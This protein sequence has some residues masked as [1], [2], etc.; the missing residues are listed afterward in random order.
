MGVPTEAGLTL[1]RGSVFARLN[2][3]PV[4]TICPGAQ[5]NIVLTTAP[6]YSYYVPVWFPSLLHADNIAER[7]KWLW[8]LKEQKK[9]KRGPDASDPLK[10][11]PQRHTAIHTYTILQTLRKSKNYLL[12]INFLSAVI[13]ALLSVWIIWL[14]TLIGIAFR[15]FSAHS[16]KEE[17]RRFLSFLGIWSNES[18]Y[19]TSTK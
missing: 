6:L 1:W 5:R 2:Y 4:V 18:R 14:Y 7:G 15:S 8:L 9:I 10:Y 12:I 13:L 3:I 11:A 16:T 19:T 17:M